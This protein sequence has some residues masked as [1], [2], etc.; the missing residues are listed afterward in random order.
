[1]DG[2]RRDCM[3][4]MSSS[5]KWDADEAAHCLCD[6]NA[7][8]RLDKT[9][10][11]TQRPGGVGQAEARIETR[12]PEGVPPNL[13]FNIQVRLEEAVANVIMYGATGMITWRLQSTGSVADRW[14]PA[15]GIPAAHS[16]YPSCAACSSLTEV[17]FGGV[18]LMRSFGRFAL[19]TS[20]RLQS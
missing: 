11:A 12:A 18:H 1:M 5:G 9:L 2:S 8:G 6:R 10:G 7:M 19:W 14:S 20:R 13:S 16:I 15:S 3:M 4:M 17:Q